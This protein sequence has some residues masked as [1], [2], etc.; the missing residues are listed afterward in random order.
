MAGGARGDAVAEV[1]LV[2]PRDPSDA[3][4]EAYERLRDLAATDA[5]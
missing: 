2:V 1:R 4:R 5:P 3:Q